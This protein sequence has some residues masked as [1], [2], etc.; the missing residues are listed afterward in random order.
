MTQTVKPI[1]EGSHTVTPALT[2]Q[3]AAE[4]I[5]YYKRAFGAIERGRMATPDGR[6][7][8]AELQ[9][10]DSQVML[11]DEFPGMS[12][13]SPKG[14]G[15]TPVQLHLYVE[16]VDAVFDRAVEAGATVKMPVSDM[17]WGDRYGVVIDP[18]GHAWGLATHIEDVPP[19]EMR[20]RGEA[21]AA[22][23]ASKAPG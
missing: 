23:L 2:V 1:P 9:F 4:A 20:R 7:M 21:M 15:G 8:H 22:G 14:L 10:G 13:P 5:E 19:D 17:F 3:G 16:D 12:H 6:I 18:F 11:S